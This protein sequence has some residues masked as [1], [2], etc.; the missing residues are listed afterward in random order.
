MYAIITTKIVRMSYKLYL[1]LFKSIS[2]STLVGLLDKK[3]ISKLYAI[4]IFNSRLPFS[5]LKRNLSFY[6]FIK[7]LRPNF[8][9]LI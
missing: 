4:A 5:T 7:A 6:A 9:L 8:K 2:S 3:A 1:D